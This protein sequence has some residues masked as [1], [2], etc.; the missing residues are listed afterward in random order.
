MYI[1]KYLRKQGKTRMEC[2]GIVVV[3]TLM[4]CLT[5]GVIYQSIILLINQNHKIDFSLVG[6]C[7]LLSAIFLKLS[8]YTYCRLFKK[9]TTIM[10]LA[11]DHL[12]D[13]LTNTV[14]LI[15]AFV[16]SKIY[17]LWWVD[18]VSAILISIYVLYSW[19][20]IGNEEIKKIL[21]KVTDDKDMLNNINNVLK[22]YQNNVTINNCLLYHCGGNFICELKIILDSDIS[23]KVS[24]DICKDIKEEIEIIKDI[25]RAFVECSYT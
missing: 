18:P 24:C 19:L 7:L 2:I 4:I 17:K 25:E 15:G 14:A 22:K 20:N 21:G 8:L 16:A 5:I 12:N 10:T 9:S 13:V 23:F 1:N 3:S 11:Q 6:I